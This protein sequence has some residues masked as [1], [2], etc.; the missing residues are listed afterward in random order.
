[1]CRPLEAA[2]QAKR[3]LAE[4]YTNPG[5]LKC[6]GNALLFVFLKYASRA[7]AGCEHSLQ[8]AAWP[9][10]KL[11]RELRDLIEQDQGQ[12]CNAYKALSRGITTVRGHPTRVA[13]G[14]SLRQLK[15]FGSHLAGVRPDPAAA[16]RA[17]RLGCEAAC[18]SHCW[19][20][21]TAC[22]ALAAAWGM[23]S[24]CCTVQV[25]TLNITLSLVHARAAGGDGPVDAVPA[26]PSHGPGAGGAGSC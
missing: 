10:S 11:H 9:H 21:G 6:H 1:M 7:S 22:C 8:L 15:G 14:T 18:G 13:D 2:R 26:R 23:I 20:C 12:D 17:A 19:H 24:T 16:A 4:G 3:V 25:T 5:T